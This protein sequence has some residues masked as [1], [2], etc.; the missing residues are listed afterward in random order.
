MAKELIRILG[1]SLILSGIF[2][3]F[4][5]SP[6]DDSELQEEHATLSAQVLQLQT[7]LEET[8][9]ELAHLQTL[10]SEANDVQKEM[11]EDTV[12]EL[13]NEK[14]ASDAEAAVATLTLEI[15]SG[16]TS[17]DVAKML[18]EANIIEEAKL[19]NDYLKD[20]ELTKSIQIGK[21][22]LDASMSIEAISKI[23]TTL[24]NDE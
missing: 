6:K 20:Q 14:P 17:K 8:E 7:Q 3:Y 18:E 16:T 4:Y 5:T 12:T 15:E 9:R 19:F 24:P 10:T 2:L 22:H 13:E 23:I 21:H 11:Q 1:I